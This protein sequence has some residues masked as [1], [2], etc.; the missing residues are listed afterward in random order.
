MF[1][2]LALMVLLSFAVA[3]G[4]SPNT[5]A[6]SA[7]ASTSAPATSVPA[8]PTLAPTTAP[9]V[10]KPTDASKPT[11]A[12]KAATAATE[13]PKVAQATAA[14]PAK[15][16]GELRLALDPAATKARF[17]V[18]EQFANQ[19][20]MA[21]AVGETDKVTG[22]LVIDSTGKINRDQS[23]FTVDMNSLKTDQA[24][25][26]N[27]IKRGTL[28]VSQFPTAQFV[29]TEIKGLAS[30]LPTSGEVQFQLVGDMT[31]RGVTKP[32]TWDVT[33]KIEGQSLVGQAK[34]AFKFGDFGMEAP[35]V[36]ILA[37][38]EDNIRLELDFKAN[39]Q[40]V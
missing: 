23:K 15:A 18:K 8:A 21:E 30:P 24:Q 14:P 26:D 33:G 5:P 10:A 34:T 28:G 40:S 3:C 13:A 4:S 38:V 20:V 17:R 27:F 1:R 37:A 7:P 39:S 32:V 22:Q 25:R 6:A 19:T 35:R 16:A 36:P 2:F 12:P 9:A 31:V 29:P 11:D